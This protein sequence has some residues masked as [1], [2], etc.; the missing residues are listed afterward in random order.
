MDNEKVITHQE[1]EEDTIDLLE[2]FFLL[3]RHLLV[4][5]LTAVLF[6]VAGFAGTTMFITPQYQ[7][8]ATMIVNTRQDQTANVTNDQITS[9]RNLVDTYSIIIKSDTVLDQVIANLGLALNYEELNAKVSVSAVNDTQVMQIA[10]TD[11]NPE[12]ARRIAEEITNVAPGEI[13]EAVEAGSVKV[14]SAA[15]AGEYPVSPSKSRNTAIAG[16]LGAVLVIGIVVIKELLN[17]TVKTDADIQK[18]LGLNVLGVIPL[19]QLP[20]EKKISHKKQRKGAHV[21]RKLV[22][23]SSK[24]VPF[25]YVEAF[26]SLRTNLNFVALSG[27]CK[28]IIVTSSVSLEG[29][30]GTAINL[31]TSLAEGG[32]RVILL[33]CDLRKPILHRY[34][35]ISNK[36]GM[37]LT[38]ILSGS[39]TLSETVQ[40]YGNPSFHVLT[41]GAVPPNPAELLG[42]NKMRTLIAKLAEVYDYILI[43][44]P[45]ATVVTDAA[46]IGSFVDGALLVVRQDFANVDTVQLAKRNLEATNTQI[47]GTVLNDF[48]AK[49]TS[50]SSAYAYAYDNNYYTSNA[51]KDEE[52]APRR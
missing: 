46:V 51:T 35:R 19:V 41:A 28:T 45:P 17:N 39:T 3:R 16:L 27:E 10:V 7:A 44:T 38:G 21:D 37:G 31:A 12:S 5:V 11:P 33:D 49:T 6:A 23:I 48:D 29:K 9:A 34:L 22:S 2:I 13:I 1:V 14:I 50:Y 43:D 36:R 25:G 52:A 32:K 8:T 24:E 15:R 18:K 30:S 26:K 47:L 20:G 40:V 4:I 42:S